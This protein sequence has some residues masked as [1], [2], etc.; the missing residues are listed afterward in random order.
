MEAFPLFLFKAEVGEDDKED[1][2]DDILVRKF[3]WICKNLLKFENHLMSKWTL[4]IL[5]FGKIENLI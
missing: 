5:Q 2:E 4:I 3:D 1:F